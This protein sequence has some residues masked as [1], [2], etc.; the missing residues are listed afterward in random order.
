MSEQVTRQ[1]FQELKQGFKE[2]TSTILAAL[3]VMYGNLSAMTD[4][5]IEHSEA[6][7]KAYIE[8]GVGMQAQMNGEAI[9]GIVE[10]LAKVESTLDEVKEA[11]TRHDDELY[12]LRKA[13]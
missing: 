8:N 11:V 4:E 6:M 13:K 12:I 9:A 7:I 5:K 2:F 1:D 10:Q 3:N